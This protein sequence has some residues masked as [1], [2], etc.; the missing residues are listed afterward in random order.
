MKSILFKNLNPLLIYFFFLLLVSIIPAFL[1]TMDWI[2]TS[3]YQF[4]SIV[5]GIAFYALLAFLV[6]RLKKRQFLFALVLVFLIILLYIFTQPFKLE[7]AFSFLCK[8]TIFLILVL[9]TKQK[10]H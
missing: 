4:I 2:S 10:N 6:C 5:L 8:L 7:T 9:I 3:L 1:Y